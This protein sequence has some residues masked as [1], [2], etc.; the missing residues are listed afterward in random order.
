MREETN[1]ARVE[2]LVLEYAQTLPDRR[3]LDVNLS[4]REDLA[5]ESLSLVSLTVR[6]GDELGVDV[7]DSGV[8]LGAVKTLGD[9]VQVA[10]ALSRL[11]R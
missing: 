10:N 1:E 4:L 11:R 2:R 5:I 6:L 9:L 3:P 8:E 7:L